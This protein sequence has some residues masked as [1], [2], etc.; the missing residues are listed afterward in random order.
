MRGLPIMIVAALA[1][2]AG[3]R[4]PPPP[5]PEPAR[6]LVEWSTWVRIGWGVESGDSSTVAARS[7]VP[8]ERTQT[9]AWE[10]AIGAD[11]TLPIA[12]EGDVR[13]GPWIEAR[14]LSVVGGGE[15]VIAALPKRLDMF[16]Y[17]GQGQLSLRAGGNTE[18]ATAAI[19]YGYRAPWDLFGR[20]S[21]STRYMIGVRVVASVTREFERPND[22]VGTLGLE[23]E[24]V[25]A[26]RYVFGIRSWY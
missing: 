5:E 10:G 23:L 14:G 18:R 13:V 20:P 21:G 9:M 7:T 2:D 26:L 6:P 4:P 11:F 12:A 8:A 16:W 17:E 3:A 24:P 25:G 1:V 22:W 15:L 19:A